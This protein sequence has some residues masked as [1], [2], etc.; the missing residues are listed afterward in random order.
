MEY[1][2]L[3]DFNGLATLRAVVE[4]GGV[5]AAGCAL[6]IG[7]PAVTKRLRTLWI[8]RTR[9]NLNNPVAEA[10]IGLLRMPPTHEG[11]LTRT[12]SAS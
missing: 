4:R 11:R 8:A 9:S 10:F 1:I 2:D 7:Q 5:D 6:N 3:P 12:D